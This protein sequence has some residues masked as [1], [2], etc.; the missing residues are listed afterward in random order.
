MA[1]VVDTILDA[2]LLSIDGVCCKLFFSDLISSI[3]DLEKPK[4]IT[5]IDIVIA[6]LSSSIHLS[7]GCD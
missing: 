5:E 1:S 6:S 2:T 7:F 3:K 4:A